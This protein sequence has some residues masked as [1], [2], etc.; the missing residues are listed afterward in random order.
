MSQDNINTYY[1]N[2]N[3]GIQFND[4]IEKLGKSNKSLSADLCEITKRS[5][6]SILSDIPQWRNG[7][8]LGAKLRLTDNSVRGTLE[9]S[10]DRLLQAMTGLG[11]PEDSE[12][13][14]LIQEET[15]LNINYPKEIYGDPLIHPYN[16]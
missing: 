11:I 14:K 3:F 9:N 16:E 1:E 8:L 6:A 12:M 13:L 7:N 5:E 2:K 15:G 10:I 4:W